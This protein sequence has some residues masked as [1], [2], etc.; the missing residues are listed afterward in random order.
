MGIGVVCAPIAVE[1]GHIA[2]PY[3][4]FDIGQC[5]L[6]A[7]DGGGADAHSTFG[8]R[9]SALFWWVAT[10]GNQLAIAVTFDVGTS[11]KC[12]GAVKV[13]KKPATVI[14]RPHVRLS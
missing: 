9:R 12:R 10:R 7:R 2:K 4:R 1:N 8:T 14:D 3:A 5:D 6:L 11:K 13:T